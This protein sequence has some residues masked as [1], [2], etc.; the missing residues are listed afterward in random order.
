MKST[1]DALFLKL[2]MIAAIPAAAVLF[3]LT[4]ATHD[5][6]AIL[7]DG[8]SPVAGLCRDAVAYTLNPLA[9]VSYAGFA[10]LAV[11]SG[12]LGLIAAVMTHMRTR[13]RLQRELAHQNET[14]RRLRRAAQA[15]GISRIRLLEIH[16]PRAYT[17]GYL[18]PTVGVSRGLLDCLDDVELEALLRHEGAHV[19]K[20]DPLRMLV[21]ITIT[22]ALVFAPVVRRFYGALQVAKEIEADQAVVESMGSSMSLVS[23]LIAAGEAPRT[24][25][26]IA[27]F[28]DSLSA[29]ISW[30]EGEE[31]QLSPMSTWR[32]TAITLVAVLAVAAGLFVIATGALDAHVLHVCSG[33]ASGA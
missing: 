6:K 4:R 32:A 14:P 3:A 30:L 23:A 29:R 9:H 31:S 7:S 27:G 19:R 26:A 16:E 13:G 2:L 28:S 10:A 21:A 20:R 12:S 8:P 11:L 5:L 17:F 24:G 22:R 18:R 25:D 15:L 33:A 1:A